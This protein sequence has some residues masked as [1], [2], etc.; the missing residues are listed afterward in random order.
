MQSLASIHDRNRTRIPAGLLGLVLLA[1]VNV[2]EAAANPFSAAFVETFREA[3]VPERLSYEGTVGHAKALGWVAVE[4]SSY[5]EFAKVMEHSA[6]GLE[7]AKADGLELSFQ[8]VALARK[9]E[10]RDLHLIVS[11]TGSEFLDQ[12]SCYLYDFAATAPVDAAAVGQMLGIAAPAQSMETAEI[13]SHVWG[14]PPSMPRTL[15]TYLT[16]IPAGSPHVEQT[17]FDG[18]VLKFSTS[19]PDEAGQ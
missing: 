4:P 5:P 10:S 12:I 16:Y 11:F 3:C 15:D 18:V 8:H 9:V 14:P 13:T 2:C 17:G 1:S 6:K 19:A 7:E